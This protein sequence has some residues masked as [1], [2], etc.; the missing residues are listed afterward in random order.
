[1][2]LPDDFIKQLQQLL[3]EQW[4]SLAETITSSEPSASVRVNVAKT[5]AEAD[6]SCRVPWCETGFYLDERQQFTF[7]VD[8]QRGAY[9]VQDASSMFINHVIKQIVTEPVRYLDLCAAPGGK[10][11]TALGALPAGSLVVA[12]EIVTLRANILKENVAKWGAPNCVVTNNSPKDFG[13][14][15]NFFDVIA[16]DVPCSG[17][18]MMRKDDEAVSQWSLS[19]VEECATR[20]RQIIDD[21]WSALRPGGYLI[22]STCTYNREENERMVDYIISNYEAQSVPI[23]VDDNWKIHEAIASENHC[24]RFMP[25][26]T[27]GEGLFVAVL[28]K[29]GEYSAKEKNKPSKG[30]KQV[31]QQPPKT[32]EQWL[33]QSGEYAILADRDDVIAM[34]KVHQVAIEQLKSQL[35]VL[36]AGVKL[37]VIKGKNCVPAHEL[38]LSQVLNDEAFNKCDVDYA[39]A[40]T[41]LRG[42]TIML[43]SNVARGYVLLTYKGNPIGFVNNLGN[44]ANNLIVKE[45]RVRSSHVPEQSPAV[46]INNDN[47]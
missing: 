11:T 17:E 30:G 5:A 9:Y 43:P 15:K 13:R 7:D 34:P 39:T 20:Q 14:L 2:N 47:S 36:L 45:W 41:F 37:G 16:T 3:P 6:A 19:L 26:F 38:A 29:P 25:C 46:L 22:Y 10:T 35:K 18:G 42:E 44:R 27:R 12:N 23:Q 32:L 24:Y 4:Q 33:K 31:K 40:M 21:I 8:F 1:M 28:R